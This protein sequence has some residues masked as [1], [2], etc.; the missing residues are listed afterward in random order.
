MVGNWTPSNALPVKLNCVSV[1]DSP[2]HAEPSG[3]DNGERLYEIGGEWPRGLP[4]QSSR[5]PVHLP[6][7]MAFSPS[8][9]W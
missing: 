4:R 6:P 9:F 3:T 1:L 5:P 8:T 7:G 2:K